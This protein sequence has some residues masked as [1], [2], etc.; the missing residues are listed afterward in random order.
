MTSARGTPVS[1]TAWSWLAIL[2][3]SAAS[4]RA[5]QG[6]PYDWTWHF[7]PDPAFGG[8]FGMHMQVV[9]VNFDGFND[10]VASDAQKPASGVIAAGKAFVLFGPS[11][12]ESIEIVATNPAP[13]EKLGWRSMS[14]GDANGDGEYDVLLGAPGYD[15]GG[16]QS[17]DIGRAHLFLGPDFT[18]NIVFNDPTPEPGALFGWAVLLADLDGDGLDD[19]TIGAPYKSRPWGR[20]LLPD[21]G[22]AVVWSSPDYGS[23][24][25]VL[26]QPKPQA[27]GEYGKN[28]VAVP[29]LG[30]GAG[31][32]LIVD[33][34]Y[35][36]PA[37][38][39]LGK[40]FLYRYDG[41]SL[42]LMSP[43]YPPM[44]ALL[45]YAEFGTQAD[46]N[47]D[48]TED[49]LV[50]A[51]GGPAYVAVVLG[52]A[53]ETA[54]ATFNDEQPL[55]TGYGD[56]AAMAD[57][58]RDGHLD[59][60]IGE[61]DYDSSVAG[62]VHVSWGPDFDRVESFG[63]NWF[64]LDIW[65]LGNAVEAGDIDGDGYPEVFAQTPAFFS[66]GMI[67]VLRRRSLQASADTLSVST[68]AAIA[69][70]LDL[71]DE[72]AGHAYLAA[73]SLSDPGAGLILGPG[74]YLPLQ[75][76]GMTNIGLS[77]LGSPILQGFAGLL[78][79]S[80]DAAFTLAWP[81]GA[82]GDLGGRTLHVAAI[83][84][85]PGGAPGAGSNAL[86]IALQP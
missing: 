35:Y 81:A 12:A 74:S 57:L 16:L 67:H 8:E 7:S 22:Q 6:L 23:S 52:P 21:A 26:F 71:P 46:V 14:V 44:V 37:G 59:V 20:T 62:A 60:L 76:D 15:A 63:P 85:P 5:Q 68:G 51:F 54:H 53:Y 32:D 39:T 47:G 3:L 28:L 78:D 42:A 66:G 43:V 80:G 77:L 41:G 49:L 75:P 36:T 40:G 29:P 27:Y 82:G 9:D 58:D 31:R 50:Y 38:Q 17:T 18:T 83:T 4:V 2:L 33:A 72:R 30:G 65:G 45:Q 56:A 11:L 13:T 25:V 34:E 24:P 86:Q 79:S 10:L 55:S 69:F 73:L 1:S 48:G 19:V 70:T 61:D 84:A 64:G